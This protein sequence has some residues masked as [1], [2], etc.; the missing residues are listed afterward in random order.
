MK[1]VKSVSSVGRKSD[2]SVQ[3]KYIVNYYK[4]FYKKVVV[5]KI[6]SRLS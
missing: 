5:N 2:V 4:L 1:S 6:C 3:S